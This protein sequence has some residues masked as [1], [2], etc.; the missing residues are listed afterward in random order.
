[1]S[2]P[3][4]PLWRYR[5]HVASRTIVAVAGGYLLAAGTAALGAQML[6]KLGVARN[7]AALGSTMLAFILQAVAFMWAF[8]CTTTRRAWLGV[9]PAAVLISALAWL[10]AQGQGG[11]PT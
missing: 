1:M 10:L 9:M 5:A 11:L 4:S 7:D 3:L 6:L 2:K 8:G